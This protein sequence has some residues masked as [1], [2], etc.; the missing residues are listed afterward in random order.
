MGYIKYS[1][2][3]TSICS[4]AF[5]LNFASASSTALAWRELQKLL[6]LQYG[7]QGLRACSGCCYKWVSGFHQRTSLHRGENG[8][9]GDYPRWKFPLESQGVENWESALLLNQVTSAVSPLRRC[10]CRPQLGTDTLLLLSPQG[11]LVSHWLYRKVKAVFQEPALRAI[12]YL[13][14]LASYLRIWAVCEV[15]VNLSLWNQPEDAI[16]HLVCQ[17]M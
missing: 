3:R 4:S 1:S 11:C 17:S 12:I 7:W 15:W 16:K 6:G 8:Q 9:C 10:L 5:D 13:Y 14:N 2:A